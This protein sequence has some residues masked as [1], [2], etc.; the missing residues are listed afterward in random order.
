MQIKGLLI[1]LDGTVYENGSLIDGV[2]DTINLLRSNN[3]PFRFVTNTTRKSRR[4]IVEQLAKMGLDVVP[5]DLFT[6]PRAAVSWLRE[7]DIERLC[8]FLPE[9]CHEEFDTFTIDNESPQAIL[10]GDLGEDW[11]YDILNKG[12]RYLIDGARLVAIQKNRFWKTEDGV[13]LDAGPFVAALEF[14]AN[15]N[16]EIIGK[17]TPAFFQAAAD[18][19]DLTIRDVA[20]IGDDIQSDVGGAQNAGAHGILVHTG[21]AGY[22]NEETSIRPYARLESIKD[23]PELLS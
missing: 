8:L 4:I 15:V 21:K 11:S 14:A 19:M 3:I 13:S 5:D 6:A 20:M 1:D 23:L 10:I 7:R 17:P 2:A 22:E 16:A 12:F 18:S 9:A